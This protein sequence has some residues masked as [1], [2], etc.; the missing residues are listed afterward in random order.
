MFSDINIYFHDLRGCNVLFLSQNL[1]QSI[2]ARESI[3]GKI[4]VVFLHVMVENLSNLKDTLAFFVIS[5]VLEFKKIL[6]Y[7]DLLPNISLVVGQ[8][9]DN[10]HV[11]LALQSCS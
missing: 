11:S 10:K 7:C 6:S 5:S 1:N 2:Q 9:S 8:S 3:T 4:L